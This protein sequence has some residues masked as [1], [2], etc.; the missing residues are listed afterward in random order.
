ML[1][2]R[3]LGSCES[4]MNKYVAEYYRCPERYIN[5]SLAG[6]LSNEEGYF[7]F[8][9][10]GLY[11][12]QVCGDRPSA[13]PNGHLRD[14]TSSVRTEGGIT[15]LPF[16]LTQ[17]TDN[18]RFELYSNGAGHGTTYFSSLLKDSY[19]L[20]RPLLPD[21]FRRHL[22][23]ARL[24]DW[25]TLTFPRWPVDRSVD[26]LFEQILLASLRAQGLKRVPFIWFWPDG[27]PGC[28]I[29]T[30]DVE[31]QVGRDHCAEVM[32]IEDAYGIP[33]CFAV[34]P[35]T[36]YEVT[37]RYLES[38]GIRGFEIAIH[39]LNH[40]GHL[41]RDRKEFLARAEKINAYGEQFGAKGF[42]AAVLYRN[43]RW[44]DA[45]K[46][47]YDMS[48]P[49]VAHLEAQRG[50]CCTVMPYFVDDI[51][52]LP[53]TTLQDYALFNYLNEYSI[54]LWKQQID[55]IM[56]QHG[57]MSFIVHPDYIT[58]PRERDVFESLLTY[59]AGL[60]KKKGLW[61]TTPG[62]V[63]QWWRQRTKMRLVEGEGKVSIE[64]EGSDR[65]RIAY[66]IER[67]GRLEFDF[68]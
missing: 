46:F 11:Y 62:D 50:G 27:A 37:D 59:L 12:G 40:D 18:L 63:D 43:Q 51:L 1:L 38:V 31:T 15:Y 56:A 49:N 3:P 23:K 28:A 48:V 14:V 47:S 20:L 54:D 22:Q 24:S 44:F 34:V 33:S 8:G 42:R 26:Q 53:V 16:D 6:A 36:R 30:H 68:E 32:D 41:F 55:L 57:L 29:M 19:Y 25:R 17:V 65:A 4:F 61:V 35:Q 21:S 5:V 2:P 10:R 39:D 9:E 60:R 52:E 7:K 66:A 45:L 13:T 67:E 58:Q 64:G